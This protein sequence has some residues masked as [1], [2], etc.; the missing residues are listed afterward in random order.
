MNNLRY[1]KFHETSIMRETMA[2]NLTYP[3]A[4]LDGEM[5]E[6]KTK[7]SYN[8]PVHVVQRNIKVVFNVVK[9]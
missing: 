7:K 1:R 3:T 6:K 9:I 8:L 5:P 2:S 4:L